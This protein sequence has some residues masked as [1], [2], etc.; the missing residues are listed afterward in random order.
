LLTPLIETNY[1]VYKV[2]KPLPVSS[3]KA[4]KWFGE[5]G[6]GRQYKTAHTVKWL[7]EN[8]YLAEIK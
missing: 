6:G 3:G 2:I 5:T 4:T 7:L 1:H 8:G